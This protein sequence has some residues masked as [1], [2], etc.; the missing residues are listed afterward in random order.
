VEGA[1][2]EPELAGLE[3]ELRQLRG[4]VGVG[5]RRRDGALEVHLYLSAEADAAE[6]RRRASEVARGHLAEPVAI[7]I[8]GGAEAPSLGGAPP[9]RERA[10]LLAVRVVEGEVEVHLSRR[11]TRTVGRAAAGRPEG[12]VAATI[13]AVEALGFEIPYRA[14]VL[15]HARVGLEDLV[16]VLLRPG[17]SHADASRRIGIAAAPDLEESASRAT[18]NALNRF[19]EP[20]GA[21]LD[22]APA[23]IK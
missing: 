20:R 14:E 7:E 3:L 11:G 8:E 16:V 4:V 15:A 12:P 23:S 1:V 17:P 13:E 22:D 18:L 10:R 19:L 9:G 6:V 5:V 21:G 2:S